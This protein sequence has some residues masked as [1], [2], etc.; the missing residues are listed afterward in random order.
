MKSWKSK[1]GKVKRNIQHANYPRKGKILLSTFYENNNV[2]FTRWQRRSQILFLPNYFG[3][4]LTDADVTVLVALSVY[5]LIVNDTLPVSSQCV[6]V[7]GQYFLLNN[8]KICYY[9]LAC[10][11]Y[12]EK[13][14]PT[15]PI[16][17]FG[18]LGRW[19]VSWLHR[20]FSV[21]A[22]KWLHYSI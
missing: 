17:W 19:Y 8:A 22:G 2:W 6:P 11:R 7:F 21:S 5:Q 20:R 18:W 16:S 9:L 12:E 1:R 15:V 13:P 14:C 10:T 4:C 3:V